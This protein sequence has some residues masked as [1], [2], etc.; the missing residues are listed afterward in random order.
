MG[1]VSQFT[2]TI[3]FQ[4]VRIAPPKGTL[5]ACS[6]WADALQFS[7][8]KGD[9]LVESCIFSG[10][11]DD[12]VNVHG[13]HLRILSQ[14]APNQLQL[15]FMHPQTYGFAAFAPGDEV[16]VINH[17]TLRELTDNPRRRVT[18]IAPLPGDTTGK[19]WL[20]TLDGPAP[21]F[22]PGDVVDN[23]T[24]YPQFTARSN[25]VT[26]ASCRGF[27]ITTRGRVLVEENLFNRCAMPAILVEGDAE[28]WFESG[29][30]RDMLI[31]Q[32]RFVGCGV[33]INPH[34]SSSKPE[35]PVHGS[36]RIQDNIFQDAAISARSVEH[37]AVLDNRFSTERPPI[38]TN[39]CVKVTMSG[40]QPGAQEALG[41]PV[42]VKE[43]AGS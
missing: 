17:A 27:L 34:T 16:A 14:P 9:V 4:R 36:I 2:D 26:L 1:I 21:A 28:G 33:E 10:L 35:E 8:C 22:G 38:H 11:Q 42:A 6:C 41:K 37:L 40:N 7:G 3:T 32:N 25:S 15:R 13:T 18:A 30:V 19:D 24:W 23:L 31:R 20:L 43:G 29:P 5:R 39:G 12:A